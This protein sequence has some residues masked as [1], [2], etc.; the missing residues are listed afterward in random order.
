M[1]TMFEIVTDRRNPW[2]PTPDWT[3]D[4]VGDENNFASL[5]EA[6]EA[7][8]ELRQLGPEWAEA[9]Y[10]VRNVATGEVAEQGQ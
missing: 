9:R 10:G 7:I 5:D 8:D 4:T 1:M 3:V 2:E 6:M